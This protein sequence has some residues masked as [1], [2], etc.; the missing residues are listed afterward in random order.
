MEVCEDVARLLA[1]E[2]ARARWSVPVKSISGKEAKVEK[3]MKPTMMKLMMVLM[4]KLLDHS[5]D[6]WFETGGVLPGVSRFCQWKKG[7]KRKERE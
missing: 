7:R 5:S 4:S 2:A 6:E 3:G 1:G